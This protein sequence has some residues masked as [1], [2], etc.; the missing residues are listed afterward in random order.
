MHHPLSSQRPLSPSA[1]SFKFASAH[2]L[3]QIDF[4]IIIM[5]ELQLSNSIARQAQP[6]KNADFGRD[7]ETT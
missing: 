7:L 4:I 3:F 6:R 5:Y 2:T 1:R